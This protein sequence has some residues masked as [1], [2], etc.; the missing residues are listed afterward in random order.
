MTFARTLLAAM[1]IATPAMAQP[2]IIPLGKPGNSDPA[3]QPSPVPVA[4]PQ[5]QPAV[6]GQAGGGG[7]RT[8]APNTEQPSNDEAATP[9]RTEQPQR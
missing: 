6:S 5:S 4:P 9:P 8:A 7:A 3:P 1:L 2:F